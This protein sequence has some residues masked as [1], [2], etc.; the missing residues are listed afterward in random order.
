ML[1]KTFDMKNLIILLFLLLTFESCTKM[2]MAEPTNEEVFYVCEIMG[3]VP[4]DYGGIGAIVSFNG[5]TTQTDQRGIYRFN[6]VKVSSKHN[7]IRIVK[8]GYYE[9]VRVFMTDRPA[10]IKIRSGLNKKSCGGGFNAFNGSDRQGNKYSYT[11]LPNSIVLES[12]ISYT[13]FVDLCSEYIDP[14]DNK[15][16]VGN[17][18]GYDL[19]NKPFKLRPLGVISLEMMGVGGQNIRMAEGKTI[20]LSV[21]IPDDMLSESPTSIILWY[22]DFNSG[23]WREG[24]IAIR[25]GSKYKANVSKVGYWG[26]HLAREAV[27]ISGNTVLADGNPVYH[28]SD[29]NYV[30]GLSPFFNYETTNFDGS[31]KEWA[32][33]DQNLGI[34]FNY[35][36]TT[37]KA[38]VTK[39][40][41]ECKLGDIKLSIVFNK[42]ITGAVVDCNNNPVKS[43]YIKRRSN[44]SDEVYVP[45]VNGR[46]NDNVYW[47]IIGT[48][49][50]YYPIDI[51]NNQE[52]KPTHAPVSGPADIGTIIA[53]NR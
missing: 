27:I 13:S 25:D 5:V 19:N 47:N 32:P 37:H 3:I 42:T 22:F 20:S 6:E 15:S 34:R 29:I 48:V 8:E 12:G 14:R 30:Q 9:D 2:E 50:S 21:E 26:F 40:G 39:C 31:F 17:F 10:I 16:I 28:P 44:F 18:V 45:V 41:Q 49:A 24:G 4:P 23:Y 38:D 46:F 51:D 43:G 36:S 33:K 11:F 1:H 7:L 35:G 52:S 53:C